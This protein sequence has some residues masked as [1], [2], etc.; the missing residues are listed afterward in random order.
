MAR[1]RMV[2]MENAHPKVKKLY[3]KNLAINSRIINEA[4]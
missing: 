1:V 3:E 4:V 2:E